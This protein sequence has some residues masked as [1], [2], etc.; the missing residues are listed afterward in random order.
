MSE[1]TVIIPNDSATFPYAQDLDGVW[2]KRPEGDEWRGG[3]IAGYGGPQCRTRCGREI[4]S[5]HVS[6][7]EPEPDAS[8]GS[9]LC[10]CVTGTT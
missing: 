7:S 1:P 3:S 8:T 5:V 2:H 10:P 6:D 4:H 9:T